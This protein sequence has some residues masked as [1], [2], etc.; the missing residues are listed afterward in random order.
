MK[1]ARLT[2]DV[3][4]NLSKKELEEIQGMIFGC[5]KETKKCKA[6]GVLRQTIRRELPLDSKNRDVCGQITAVK[7]AMR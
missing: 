6:A 2:I 3:E 1:K 4:T 5:L 7:V